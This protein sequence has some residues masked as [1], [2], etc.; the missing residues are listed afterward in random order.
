MVTKNM[1]TNVWIQLGFHQKEFVNEFENAFADYINVSHATTVSNG[2]VAIHLALL[3]L[4]IGEGDE[5]IVLTSV[6]L[7]ALRLFTVTAGKIL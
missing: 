6:I 5:V 2:T 7:S 1:L 3:A 4:G